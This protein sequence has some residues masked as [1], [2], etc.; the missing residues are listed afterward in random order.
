MKHLTRKYTARALVF[1][2]V[3]ACMMTGCSSSK[4]ILGYLKFWAPTDERSVDEDTASKASALMS[5]VRSDKGNPDSHYRLGVYYQNQGKYRE[6]IEEFSK[7]VGIDPGHVYAYNG[8]GVAYDN[9]K[10]MDL[11]RKAYRM[12]LKLAPDDRHA[13]NNLGYSFI[14]EGDYGSAVEVLLEGLSIHEND[15]HMRSNLAMAYMALGDRSLARAELEQINRPHKVETALEK[16]GEKLDQLEAERAPIQIAHKEI[17]AEDI[18]QVPGKNRFVERMARSLAQAKK[19]KGRPIAGPQNLKAP[20]LEPGYLMAAT[21]TQDPGSTVPSADSS[22]G[23]IR[24]IIKT[25]TTGDTDIIDSLSRR[26][27]WF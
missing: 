6:A 20:R 13:Y 8:L 4:S 11:A 16:I 19:A 3:I 22:A 2:T 25:R 18:A 14:L 26:Q 17:S 23:Y 1:C 24:E 12:A 15:G 27:A 21:K 9:L 7:A 10:E 5:K